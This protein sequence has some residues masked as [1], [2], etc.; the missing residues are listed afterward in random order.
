[1]TFYEKPRNSWLFFIF[2]KQ[3]YRYENRFRRK[4][5]IQ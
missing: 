2:E 4:T 3:L 1:M 5:G